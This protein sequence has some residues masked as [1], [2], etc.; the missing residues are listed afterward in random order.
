MQLTELAALLNLST[1]EDERQVQSLERFFRLAGVGDCALLLQRLTV[2]CCPGFAEGSNNG[3]PSLLEFTKQQCAFSYA[4][5]VQLL[6]SLDLQF[7]NPR[8]SQEYLLSN[9]SLCHKAEQWSS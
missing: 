8:S 3:S 7:L 2:V 6:E 1:V 4:Q 5:T 9:C